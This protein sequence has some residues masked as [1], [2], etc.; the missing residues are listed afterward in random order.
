MSVFPTETRAKNNDE[1][2]QKAWEYTETLTE[3]G[4][5]EWVLTQ[6]GIENIGV[7]LKV[8]AG[9]GKIQH[10]HSTKEEIAAG[11]ETAIDWEDGV[12]TSSTASTFFNSVRAIRQVNTS[13]TTKLEYYAQ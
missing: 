8:T 3:T 4:N 6:N 9:S 10:T 12:V 13:G 2:E 1:N 5:G 11:T 7:T